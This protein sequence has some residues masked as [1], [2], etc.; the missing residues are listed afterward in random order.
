MLQQGKA[1]ELLSI[2]PSASKP[3]LLSS[4]WSI[5]VQL[6]V[7]FLPLCVSKIDADR[8]I[9]PSPQLTYPIQFSPSLQCNLLFE[10]G[11]SIAKRASVH[12]VDILVVFSKMRR[13]ICSN[14]GRLRGRRILFPNVL[15]RHKMQQK[16]RID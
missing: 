4:F 13:W 10:I 5:H 1:S 11:N 12:K 9:F 6:Q 15:L 14:C 16:I 7:S 8:A 3:S 2:H